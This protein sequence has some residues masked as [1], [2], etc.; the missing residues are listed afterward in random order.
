MLR[1]SR[2][3]KNISRSLAQNGPT[4]PEMRERNETLRPPRATALVVAPSPL[5]GEGCSKFPHEERV[6]GVGLETPTGV[7]F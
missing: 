4:A 1:P 3:T 7:R 5:A 6:R 2:R